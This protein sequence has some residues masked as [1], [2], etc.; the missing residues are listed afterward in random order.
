MHTCMSYI[1][2]DF[3][4]NH[5]ERFKEII[6]SSDISVEIENWMERCFWKM[7]LSTVEAIRLVRQKPLDLLKSLARYTQEM[8]V[9]HIDCGGYWDIGGISF[10][11]IHFLNK[12]I[13]IVMNHSSDPNMFDL[14]LPNGVSRLPRIHQLI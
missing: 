5:P 11:E 7:V 9:I 8:N 3:R 10:I 13:K 2:E 6:K 1:H 12:N 14:F 4:E